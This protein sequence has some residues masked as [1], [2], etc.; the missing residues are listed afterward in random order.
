MVNTQLLAQINAG[1]TIP[2]ETITVHGLKNRCRSR[3]EQDR[4][5]LATLRA[6]DA[7]P[8]VHHRLQS[9]KTGY[10]RGNLPARRSPFADPSGLTK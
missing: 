3:G 5:K 1:F 7:A 2:V 6:I 9:R 10:P 8:W 4:K